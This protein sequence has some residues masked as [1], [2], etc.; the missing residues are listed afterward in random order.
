MIRNDSPSV[1]E[2]DLIKLWIED[3]ILWAE[4]K[5]IILNTEEAKKIV[6]DRILFQNGT[7]YPAIADIRKIKYIN[8][9]A[10]EYL[11][12]EGNILVHCVAV[13][14][15]SHVSEILGNFYLKLSK[16]PLPT[17][18]FRS[19]EKAKA[20]VEAQMLSQ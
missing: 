10:N 13:I 2:N 6:S 11:S 4:Y 7:V 12:K 15:E 5:E 14:V 17:K 16:P 20:W 8:K 1:F 19:A 18:L 3:G 9:G